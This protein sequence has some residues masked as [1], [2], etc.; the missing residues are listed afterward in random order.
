MLDPEWPWFEETLGVA[1]VVGGVM[2]IGFLIAIAA[3]NLLDVDRLISATASYTLLL[4]ALFALALMLVP[5]VAAAFAGLAGLDARRRSSS[6]PCCS[7][8]WSCR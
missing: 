8:R 5:R 1:G 6:F 3:Y 4:A 7:P 2:P